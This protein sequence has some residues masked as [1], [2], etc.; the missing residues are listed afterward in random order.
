TH[1]FVSAEARAAGG[2]TEGLIRL[3]VGIEH[4]DD[5][6]ADLGQALADR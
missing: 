6:V 1:S 4:P 3:S 2:V 5:L